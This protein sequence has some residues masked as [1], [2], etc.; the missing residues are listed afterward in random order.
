MSSMTPAF[1]IATDLQPSELSWAHAE[2]Q[3]VQVREESARILG[4]EPQ[5][6]LAAAPWDALPSVGEI[7]VLPAPLEFSLL[8]R[9]TLGRAVTGARR[10]NPEVTIH[11]DDIDPGHPLVV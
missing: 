10:A 7:F 4:L 1:V 11:H 6:T 9:E 3:V 5:V 8:Q 2:A